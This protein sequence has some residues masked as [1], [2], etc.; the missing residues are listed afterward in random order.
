MSRLVFAAGLLLG[1][2]GEASAQFFPYTTPPSGYGGFGG[3]PR[4]LGPAI[5]PNPPSIT[6]PSYGMTGRG[7]GGGFGG[8]RGAGFPF[9]GIWGGYGYGLGY[10]YY[11]YG[12]GYP[13][14]GYGGGFTYNGYSFDGPTPVYVESQP[15]AQ[16]I[17]LANV[18][19]AVLTMEFPAPAEVWV[20]G[21]KAEGDP[22]TEWKLT[23]PELKQGETYTFG[24]KARWKSGGKTYSYERS[25]DVASGDHSR[26]LVVAGTE[27][28]E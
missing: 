28:K 21:E 17:A 19:P 20:N 10:P 12:L 24:V 2:Q 4:P 18:F 15:P 1:M 25:V 7:F 26:A 27:V 5:L 6:P 8:F 23:S 16:N 14:Y 22:S 13:Y 11:G 9:R 3:G